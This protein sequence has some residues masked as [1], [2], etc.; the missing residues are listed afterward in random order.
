M[1]TVA[2]CQPQNRPVTTG[3]HDAQRFAEL[4]AAFVYL[5]HSANTQAA[6]RND[7]DG[8]AAWCQAGGTNPL[9]VTG[10]HVEQYRAACEESGAS[11]ATVAR[12]LSALRSF[13][14]YA[15]TR[16]AAAPLQVRQ[17]PLRS[18]VPSASPDVLTAD[19]AG[20]LVS[21]S[22]LVG[23]KCLA[24][25]HL[26]LVDGLKLGELL[27]ADTDQVV[28]AG[29]RIVALSLL[30]GD[31]HADVA[32]DPRTCRAVSVYLAGR[33]IGPLFQGDS[34]T[35]AST[36]LTRFGADYLVKKAAEIAGLGR[37]VSA[38][39]LRRTHITTAHAA[40]EP[41]ASIRARLGH[42][43]VRTTQRHLPAPADDTP[44]DAEG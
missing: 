37:S 29:Q 24:L 44:P 16:G 39:T 41:L 40:G 31:A 34:P 3:P 17:Q 28:R 5:Q 14:E 19:E 4:A 35:R 26:L 22:A 13:Y 6:Y 43:D 18:A 27:A 20:A 1:L 38:S 8:F 32:L 9:S 7:L 30:R 10:A 2:C 23:P 25:V 36:R 21:A 12:R 42:A 11:R 15:A 33:T